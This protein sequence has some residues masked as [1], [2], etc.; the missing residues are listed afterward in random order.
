MYLQRAFP[1]LM[2]Q[3]C[4]IKYMPECASRCQ[5]CKFKLDQTTYTESFMKQHINNF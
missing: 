3:A 1:V 5:Y 4:I 2:T